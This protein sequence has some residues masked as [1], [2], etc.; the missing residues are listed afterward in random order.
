M[1][2]FVTFLQSDAALA[3]AFAQK[4]QSL[5]A[6]LERSTFF[7][8][9]VLL[10]STLLLVYDDAARDEYHLNLRGALAVTADHGRRQL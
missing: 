9:H 1:Q 5:R 3:T 4:V 10:R 6:A 2:A 8:R 7:Q